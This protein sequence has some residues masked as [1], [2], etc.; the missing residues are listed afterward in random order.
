MVIQNDGNLPV[1]SVT[2][3]REEFEYAPWDGR[4]FIKEY[5]RTGRGPDGQPMEEVL[6]VQKDVSSGDQG[7]DPA[8]EAVE[9]RRNCGGCGHRL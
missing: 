7:T 8:S 5:R 4:Q 1:E 9:E 2:V 3:L 6:S